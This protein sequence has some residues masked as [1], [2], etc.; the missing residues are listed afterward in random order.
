MSYE[1]EFDN[2]LIME[3]KEKIDESS[4]NSKKDKNI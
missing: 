1:A 4:P 3:K 2:T